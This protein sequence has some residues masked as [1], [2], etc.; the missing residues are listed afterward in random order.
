MLA[1][2]ENEWEK[3][4]KKL[5]KEYSHKPSIMMIRETMRRELGFMPRYH[6][7]YKEQ[8]GY[9]KTVYLDFYD[10]GTETWFRLKYL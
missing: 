2:T 4:R 6:K 10:E 1:L 5:Q 7:E 8:T 9:I 3:I